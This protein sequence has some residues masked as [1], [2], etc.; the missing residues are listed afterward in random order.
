[1]S[2][3][4]LP[5]YPTGPPSAM[6]DPSTGA[7]PGPP[8]TPPPGWYPEPGAADIVRWWD[9]HQWSGY[10]QAV[11]T[12]PP[13]WLRPWRRFGWWWLA[14]I[15]PGL[16]VAALVAVSALTHPLVL[17]LMVI[18]TVVVAATLW[19]L[20]R[21]EPEPADARVFTVAW[22]ATIAV[23]VGA[24][25]GLATQ[26]LAGDVAA[27]VVGAPAAEEIAKGAVL[28]LLVRLRL[29]DHPMN[30]AVFA[31]AVG[32]GFGI[33]E[34][35]F[36]LAAAAAE[37]GTGGLLV[38]FVLR[39]IL[40]P[41]GHPLF[42]VWMGLAAGWIA[43]RRPSR[44]RAWLVGGLS[45]VVAVGL[46]AAW[47]AGTLAVEDNPAVFGLAAAGFVVLFVATAAALIV[48]RQRQGRSIIAGVYRVAAWVGLDTNEV[49][50][51]ADRRAYGHVRRGLDRHR[52]RDLAKLRGAL[53]HLA[54]LGVA[55]P[56][57][58]REAHRDAEALTAARHDVDAARQALLAGTP[59]QHPGQ[60]A[61]QHAGQ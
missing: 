12:G 38:L 46:H 39:G 23:A 59:P 19:W 49:V 34:D 8:S 32:V 47:N 24:L 11:T 10:R 54:S 26:A 36:Y 52:R 5:S 15:L 31:I 4:E 40:T 44:R 50:A 42:T 57:T 37:E 2:H 27:S 55:P 14:V 29:V 43:L 6:W 7:T 20:D 58:P 33:V 1:M 16:G 18:P 61:G 35:I 28:V 21:L 25:G 45:V 60:H 56:R 30:G 3:P 53:V 51:V 17:P 48:L 13:R 41:F 22:G 9:G